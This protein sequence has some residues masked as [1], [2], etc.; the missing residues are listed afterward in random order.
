[1]GNIAI[2]IPA[3]NEAARLGAVLQVVVEFKKSSKDKVSIIVVDNDSVDGTPGVV[4]AAQK[5]KDSEINLLEE[6]RRG[7]KNASL[8]GINH[9]MSSNPEIIVTLDAGLINLKKEHVQALIEGAHKSG[10]CVGVLPVFLRGKSEA[11]KQFRVEMSGQRAY[12]AEKLQQLLSDEKI[13][14]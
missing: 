12:S 6:K 3:R 9:A 13:K 1:M 14:N 4:S 5:M 11:L 8:T 7:K 10:M 2:I